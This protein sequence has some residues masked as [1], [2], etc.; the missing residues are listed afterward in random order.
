MPLTLD[1]L[2]A[3]LERSREHFLKH[4]DGL[5]D[6]QWDFKPFP[7]CK[8]IRETLQHL[9]VDDRA[10]LNS[11]RSGEEP[12]Y[13]AGACNEKDIDALRALLDQSHQT[14]INEIRIRYANS[15]L[16]TDICVWGS[17]EKVGAGVPY[18]S[19]EDFYHA[20]QVAFI[21]MA[22]DPEWDYYEAI[23]GGE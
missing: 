5:D 7:E 3:G 12:D 14:L 19:S 9:V 20:G 6:D 10:A 8:S 2:L 23:Y 4:L 21:R 18:F 1:D 13:E 22:S 11:L 16:D 15:P 17:H